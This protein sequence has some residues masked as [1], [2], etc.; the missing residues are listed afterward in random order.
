METLDERLD[1]CHWLQNAAL[2]LSGYKIGR[3]DA[4]KVAAF[5]P[6]WCVEAVSLLAVNTVQAMTFTQCGSGY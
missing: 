5:I 3:T 1:E 4:I 6:K 2:D